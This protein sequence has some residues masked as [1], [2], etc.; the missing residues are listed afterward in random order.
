V[1][2]TIILNWNRAELLA[3]T[4]R[5]FAQTAV[6]PFEVTVI[7]NASSDTSREVIEEGRRLIPALR[8]IYHSE[9]LGGE[10]LNEAIERATGNLIHINENDIVLLPGWQEHVVDAFRVFGGLGQL[11]LFSGVPS[12]DYAGEPQPATL[13]FSSGKI[14]YEAHGNVGTSS[15]LRAE[16]FGVHGIRVHNLP[17]RDADAFAFPDDGR[18]SADV[19]AAGYWCAWSDRRY[20]R[21]LGHELA[22]FERD[23][24]YYR[25]NYASKPGFGT[26][27][28]SA[29]V[30]AAR[31][32]PRPR[33]YSG[34]FPQLD[35]QPERTPGNCGGA[36]ARMWSM[37]DSVT[38]EVEVLDFLNALVRLVKPRRALD[39]SGWLGR[40]A[41]AI[42]AALRDNGFGELEALTRDDGA[43]AYAAAEVAAAGLAAL[44]TFRDDAG[45]R[46]AASEPFDFAFFGRRASG[47]LTRWH[48]ALADGA[49]IVF[50]GPTDAGLVDGFA[51]NTPRG[52]WV[53]TLAKAGR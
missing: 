50:H 47:E 44:V 20:I 40:S 35:P 6:E 25:R 18:L 4:L 32:Q 27:G 16:L 38:P 14:V 49:T 12:D 48:D 31:E 9:N 26:A 46:P 11:S 23:P 45:E 24:D 8:A 2:S 34:V 28:W 17:Q 30:A 10:A 37:F 33:R 13:R 15:I 51:P 1:I 41:V 52:L 5:G 36:A 42:A 3:Q 21:N 29:R 22:E 53:G 43:A 39:T 19:K 7:D